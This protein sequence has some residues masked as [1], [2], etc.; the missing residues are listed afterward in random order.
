MPTNRPSAA[1]RAHY[2]VAEPQVDGRAYRPGWRV[3]TRLENLLRTRAIGP[4]EFR[5]GC[6]FRAAVQGAFREQRRAAASYDAGT[7][8]GGGFSGPRLG[9]L[10]YQ[11]RLQRVGA[12]LTQR[13]SR[14]CV[15]CAVE[16]LPFGEIA[17]REGCSETSAR[18]W[19]V[20]ALGALA[21]A[22]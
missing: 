17:R 6:E 22:W 16:D 18:N 8:T 9:R 11:E 21:D 14:L 19:T 15:A 10:D 1:Y 12:V 4:R 13:D 2:D 7:P 20:D 3:R 5:A